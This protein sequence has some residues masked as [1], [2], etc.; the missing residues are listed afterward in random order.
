MGRE[1]R[2]VPADWVHPV[3]SRGNEHPLY[4]ESFDD[5]CNEWH[6]AMHRWLDGTYGNHKYDL[7]PSAEFDHRTPLGFVKWHG[8]LG[9]PD[10]Y[11]PH[12]AD[13]ERTHYQLYETLSE[14]TPL[15]P[16]FASLD[17]LAEWMITT[18]DPVWGFRNPE[19]VRAFCSED[20]G[21][22]PSMITSPSR[23]VH[24]GMAIYE[25]ETS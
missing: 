8:T 6:A 9:D 13:E 22:A 10:Y 23:G 2:R 17:E 11:R 12:W 4:D 25:E 16:V 20:G 14:G 7:K 19:H 21:Y 5:A 3:D 18:P 1:I 24:D 15:S